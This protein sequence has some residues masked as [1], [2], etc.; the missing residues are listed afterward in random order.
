M[1][2]P[3]GNRPANSAKLKGCGASPEEQMFSGGDVHITRILAHRGIAN[4]RF[5]DP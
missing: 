2:S 3:R 1:I 4:L 5:G